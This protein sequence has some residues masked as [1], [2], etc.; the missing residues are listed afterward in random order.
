MKGQKVSLSQ[1]PE[2]SSMELPRG[3][4]LEVEMVHEMT[5]EVI[6]FNSLFTFL[7]LSLPLPLPLSLSQGPGQ[8]QLN[9]VYIVDVLAIAQDVSYAKKPLKER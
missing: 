1:R 9:I 4:I 3:T 7:L 8:R 5:G 6:S 2:F